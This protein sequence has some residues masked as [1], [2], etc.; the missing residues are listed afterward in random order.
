MCYELATYVN[1]STYLRLQ[2]LSLIRGKCK[3]FSKV[4]SKSIICNNDEKILAKYG[5]IE[6]GRPD[7]NQ[8]RF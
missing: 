2:N 8:G 4:R 5:T 7:S 6:Y 3:S 1:I